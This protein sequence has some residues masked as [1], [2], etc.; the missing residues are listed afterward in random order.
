MPVEK[1]RFPTVTA[2]V[3]ANMIGTGVFTSLGFQL[4]DIQ[5]GFVILMLW[6]IGGLIAVCGAMT[7]AE[8][9]AAMPRS[10][11]EYNFLT[12]IYHPAAGF[13]SGW[14]SAT[15]GFAGPSALAA[16][17]FAA[18]ATSILPGESSLWL[19]RVLAAGLIVAL[20]VIHGSS[21][22][23]SGGVQVVFT[24][25]KV[26]VILF[27]CIG[28]LVFVDAPQ[29]VRF[30]PASGDSTLMISGAFAVS[31][32]YVSYAYTGWN[33]AT[34][35]SSELENPQ[36]TLPWI[37]VT[38]TLIVT[39][40]Y[41]ALNWI[42]LLSAPIDALQGEV[43]V[44]FI[45]ARWAFGE[46]GGRFTGL[47]L[48]LLLV[49]TVSAMTIAGPRVLQVIGEDFKV[50][51]VLSRTNKDGIPVTAIYVQSA[52]A[53][54]FVMSSTFESVLVFAG[55]TLAL[56][57]FA[58]VMGV[59][60][61]RWKQPDLE[62]PY[63]TFLYPLPPLIYLALTGWTLWFVLMTRPVEGLFGLGVIGSGLIVY[64]LSRTGAASSQA[65]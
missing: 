26:A 47:V 50:L 46:T 36:Q 28:A 9:G 34:Y 27:F 5:S 20:T 63:R 24:I 56:N 48:A 38:G 41:V 17:T 54:L 10:G 3:I 18:Y 60:V 1:F 58:T 13:V 22:R 53:L 40:L 57:S 44:G 35:L 37:L 45:A 43:E 15:I 39:I 16:M 62:R 52:L 31:L 29:P 61:L 30:L 65:S 7:Y 33:A 64:F 42:F 6:A 19:E 14:T 4:L 49:S 23:S 51:S 55:F 11:G 21:R 32:I 25:L 59:F 8:L 12:R 2:V